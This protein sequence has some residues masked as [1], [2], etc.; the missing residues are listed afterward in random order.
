MFQIFYQK[1]ERYC[2]SFIGDNLFTS[3]QNMRALNFVLEKNTYNS[4]ITVKCI[5]CIH[6]SKYRE[7]FFSFK[8]SLICFIVFRCML[9][10]L[11]V[12]MYYIKRVVGA[13]LGGGVT[14]CFMC[15]MIKVKLNVYAF[16][17]GLKL[18]NIQFCIYFHLVL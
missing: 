8:F 5:E 4:G 3:K 9:L 6:S 11:L 2:P 7:Y 17:W 15:V 12:N 13:K 16:F 10:L 1:K 18:G 14:G